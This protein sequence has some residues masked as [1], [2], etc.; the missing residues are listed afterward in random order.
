MGSIFP[1][2]NYIILLHLLSTTSTVFD[3]HI[4]TPHFNP[5]F[6]WLKCREFFFDEAENGLIAYEKYISQRYDLVLMDLG[7]PVMNGSTATFQI[8]KWEKENNYKST[9]IIALMAKDESKKETEKAKE[10]GCNTF[11]A[12]PISRENLVE[13]FYDYT[14]NQD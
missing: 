9:P 3:R 5:D 6:T 7:M 10:S 12:K 4:S 2:E 1:G 13:I 11:L 8:R 14:I